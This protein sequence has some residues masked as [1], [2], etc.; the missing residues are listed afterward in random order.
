[1]GLSGHRIPD[2]PAGGTFFSA[3][4]FAVK[5]LTEGLRQ[6]VGIEGQGA[7]AQGTLPCVCWWWLL[8]VPGVLLHRTLQAHLGWRA[9]RLA[10]W[11]F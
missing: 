1:M 9:L 7:L 2:A 6:E 10:L 5:A 8:L 11:L 4:K 3:T